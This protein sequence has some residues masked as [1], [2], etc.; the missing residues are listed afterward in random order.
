MDTDDYTQTVESVMAQERAV[1]FPVPLK[2]ES[3]RAL[4]GAWVKAN[5]KAIR[6][7]EMT[8]LAIDARGLRVSTKYLIERLRYE[9]RSKLVAVPYVDQF[10]IEHRY[11]I[12][13]NVT[14]LLGR[15]LIERHPDMRIEHRKSM[16]DER[17]DGQ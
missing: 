4:F 12:N 13:N 2:A 15:W 3:Y 14:A 11:C 17:K 16:F 10:G 8:A 9:G 7:L 5:P 6:E 1:E